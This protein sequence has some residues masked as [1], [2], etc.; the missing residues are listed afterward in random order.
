METPQGKL[1]NQ[2]L[3]TENGVDIGMVNKIIDEKSNEYLIK[4]QSLELAVTK[5][6]KQLLTGQL[7]R[8]NDLLSLAQL[9]SQILHLQTKLMKLNQTF[10]KL[11]QENQVLK[12]GQQKIFELRQQNERQLTS[13]FDV[14]NKIHNQ[15]NL[16]KQQ[17]KSVADLSHLIQNQSNL[18]SKLTHRQEQVEEE[19]RILHQVV[20]NQS[21]YI[22]HVLKT[23]HVLTNQMQEER[24]QESSKKFNMFPV[25]L[26]KKLESLIS[27]RQIVKSEKTEK[28]VKKKGKSRNITCKKPQ[29][30]VGKYFHDKPVVKQNRLKYRYFTLL[31][32]SCLVFDNIDKQ[33]LP[34]LPA[35]STQYKLNKNGTVNK[36][37]ARKKQETPKS[38]TLPQKNQSSKFKMQEPKV[39]ETEKSTQNVRKIKDEPS[40]KIKKEND[41]KVKDGNSDG[42]NQQQSHNSDKVKPKVASHSKK[43]SVEAPAG[44][45]PTKG[46]ETNMKN[47]KE[48]KEG[49]KKMNNKNFELKEPLYVDTRQSGP[50]DCYDL[51]VKGNSKNGV[52]KIKPIA[53]SKSLDV[54]CDMKN[55]GWTV[56]QRRQGG[57]ISFKRD[58]NSYKKG[59]GGIYGEHWLGNDNIHW[60]TN[61]GHYSLR[62]DLTDWEKNKVTAI[63]EYFMI[64]DEKNGYRLHVDGFSG[65]SGDSLSKHN[66]NK[67]STKDVDNDLVTK[68]FGGSCAKRF[69]GAWWYYK[70]YA[71]NLNG[72]FYRD[73]SVADKKFDGIAWKSW[74]K[75]NY[76]LMKVE[77]KIKPKTKIKDS[78]K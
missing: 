22:S 55:G 47:N 52:H 51:Y 77:M 36:T 26:I 40:V 23:V 38:P 6:E 46:S 7:S 11:Q 66:L 65:D 37:I 50:K 21:L 63:Y 42:K 43:E 54:F 13:N 48:E 67:F 9:E 64:D 35:S 70:C 31:S 34:N 14:N 12:H 75:A 68:Q 16:I 74:K 20:M 1:F 49:N 44:Q 19:N 17:Q 53:A 58:W 56:I 2:R 30:S 62:V 29:I 5:L 39:K 41:M 24:I 18:L 32:K 8:S 78:N 10:I 27:D 59:F 28:H 15:N 60:L 25:Q 57:T 4:I 3:K 45:K 61:Q 73:G 72:V 76:S 71:S 33:S 69:S